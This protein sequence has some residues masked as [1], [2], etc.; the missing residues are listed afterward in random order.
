M[1]LKRPDQPRHAVDNVLIRE[2]NPARWAEVRWG[3]C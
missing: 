3:N 2:R 1:E